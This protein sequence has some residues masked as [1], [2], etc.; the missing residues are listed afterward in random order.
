MLGTEKSRTSVGV[1]LILGAPIGSLGGLREFV[2]WQQWI[3][4]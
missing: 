2:S 4:L 3:H 1:P